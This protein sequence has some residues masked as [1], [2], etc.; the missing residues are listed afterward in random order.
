M[1]DAVRDALKDYPVH[2]TP[3]RSKK[4]AKHRQ[5][6]DALHALYYFLLPHQPWQRGT[7]ENTGLLRE[8]FPKD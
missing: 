3:D 4:F 2:M 6:T 8:Y 5:V 7:N 1:S